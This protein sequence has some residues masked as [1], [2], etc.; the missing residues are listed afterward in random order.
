MT[1]RQRFLDVTTRA[2]DEDP[3]VALVVADISARF[4]DEAFARHP[5]RVLNVGIREQLLIGSAAGLALSGMRPVAHTYAPF[6]VERAFEQIKLDLGHQ[7]LG[8]LLVS[9]GASYDEPG[10]GRTH[11]APADVALLDTIPGFSIHVPGHSDE[12]E[13]LMRHELGQDGR[14]YVRTSIQHNSRPQ[15]V[16][17][18]HFLRLRDGDL[19]TIVAVGPMLD[20]ALAATHDLDVTVLYATTIRPFDTEALLAGPCSRVILV[21]PYL[22]GTSA[23]VVS[24]ALTHLP[25]QLLALGVQREETR[26]YGTPEQHDVHHGLDAPGLRR[27][28]LRWLP[29]S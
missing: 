13:V 28:I 4:L 3:R 12:V 24:S 9:T 6:L 8:A 17:V 5:H 29:D 22:A 2:L 10:Y 14:A 25:H 23:A 26:R 15:P 20:R 16:K 21:E 7:D 19:A 18:G 27:Q 11:Q 1:M